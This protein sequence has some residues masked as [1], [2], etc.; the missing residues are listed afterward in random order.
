MSSVVLDAGASASQVPAVYAETLVCGTGGVVAGSDP[1]V[2][3]RFSRNYGPLQNQTELLAGVYKD[4]AVPPAGPGEVGGVMS[5]GGLRFGNIDSIADTVAAGNKVCGTCQLIGGTVTVN[6]N[7]TN[8]ISVTN[9]SLVFVTRLAVLN[10]TAL[11]E[12]SIGAQT[13][14]SFTINALDPANP[15][16]DVAPVRVAGDTSLVQWMMINPDFS[17]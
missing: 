2:G 9:R 15:G 3:V 14:S 8:L 16:S 6:A 7:G 11:G 12:L 5:V 13:D 10:A 4:I 17:T 1:S